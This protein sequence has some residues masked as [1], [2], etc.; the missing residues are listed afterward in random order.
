MGPISISQLIRKHSG[1]SHVI[2]VFS[3]PFCMFL[4]VAHANFT[5]YTAVIVD[6]TLL[7]RLSIRKMMVVNSMTSFIA[8]TF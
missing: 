4:K 8:I 3:Q 6:R 5:S 7:T 1:Y 2:N